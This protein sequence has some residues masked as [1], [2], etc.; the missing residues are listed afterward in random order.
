MNPRTGSAQS[1]RYSDESAATDSLFADL[2]GAEA[3]GCAVGVVRDG[4]L[5]FS[6]GYGSANLDYGIP[7]GPMSSFYLASVSKQFVGAAVALLVIDSRLDLSQSIRTYVPE[8]PE[9][10]DRVTV[11]HLVHHI[12]G[13]RDYLALFELAGRSVQDFFDNDDAIELIARQKSLNFEP[14]SQYLYS[15]SGYVLLAEI[16]ERVTGQSLDE[17]S[18]ERL[19][20][21]LG[22][23][24]THWGEDLSRVVPGRAESY[25]PLGGDSYGRLI[26]NFEG[27]GD[28]NLHSTV[29]DLA[30]WDSVFYRRDEPWRSMVDLMRIRGT[31][32]DGES[33]SYA[34]GISY[35][36]YRG[37][38]GL[39]HSGGMLGYRTDI[40]RL[41][42]ERFT[43]IVLCNSGQLNPPRLSRLL[44][45][46]WVFGGPD[47]ES[48]TQAETP[49]GPRPVES[50]WEPT[51]AELEAF[52]GA[53]YSGELDV[54]YEL[55]RNGDR[56]QVSLGGR[57]IQLTPRTAGHFGGAGLSVVFDRP[58]GEAASFVLDAGRV[59]GL[60]FVRR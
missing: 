45:D 13:I 48:N 16:V 26:W 20:E 7:L 2:A 15:N 46:I 59:R 53:Y 9:Y 30:R 4:A 55:T 18:Q 22:M 60:L 25:R 34:F 51:A 21:P 38:P 35:V 14:G 19:F 42:E 49:T 1:G 5:V 8:L 28:G 58:E 56:L 12:S 57:T 37:R 43:S 36:K 27:K 40:F 44:A 50:S 39:A 24:S 32:N 54:T 47:E 23:E 33:I 11:R 31:L 29:E 52:E 10:T 41:P 6:G 17:F 3:P